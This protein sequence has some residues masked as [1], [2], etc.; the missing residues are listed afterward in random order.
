LHALQT[1]THPKKKIGVPSIAEMCDILANAI[2]IDI[3]VQAHNGSLPS[4]F[5]PKKFDYSDIDYTKYDT[6]TFIQSAIA[7][8]MDEAQEDF[9]ND[10]IAAYETFLVFLRTEE[11]TVDYTYLWDIVS[12]PNPR[13][14]HSGINLA[15]LEIPEND[16]TE[17]VEVV[18]PTAAYS[19]TIY[20]EKKDTLI[21]T[22]RT[23]ETNDEI[24]YFEPIYLYDKKQI[25]RK[26]SENTQIKPIQHILQIIRNF[27][28]KKCAPLKSIPKEYTFERNKSATQIREIC[29]KYNIDVLAQVLNFQGKI[30]AFL[31]KVPTG[32]YVYLPCAPSGMMSDI[33][34][35]IMIYDNDDDT[36]WQNYATTRD[37]LLQLSA[38]TRGELLCKP[39]VKIVEDELIVGI[40][41]ETNQFVMVNPPE[42]NYALDGLIELKDTNY[43]MADIDLANGR[44]MDNVRLRTVK[45]IRLEKYFYQVFRT[46][47][48]ILLNQSVNERTNI[49]K[50]IENL[51]YANY[52]EQLKSV[53][54]WLHKMMDSFVVFQTYDESVLMQLNEIGDCFSGEPVNCIFKSDARQLVIPERNSISGKMNSGVYFRRLADELLRY[55]RVRSMILDKHANIMQTDEYQLNTDE[56]ILLDYMLADYLNKDLVPVMKIKDARISYDFANPYKTT[57]YSNEVKLID[58]SKI[59]EEREP[60]QGVQGDQ[61]SDDKLKLECVKETKAVLGNTKN[62]WKQFFP[63]RSRELFLNSAVNC[64]YYPILII[65]KQVYDG[66]IITME[67][68]KKILARTYK[69]YAKFEPKILELLSLQGKRDMMEKVAK[70]QAT[71]EETIMSAM[72]PLSNLDYWVLCDVLKLPVILFTSMKNIKHLLNGESWIRLGESENYR[73]LDYYFIRAPTET[74]SKRGVNEI[75]AYSM[76]TPGISLEEMSDFQVIYSD[77]TIDESINLIDLKTYLAGDY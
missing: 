76:I 71:L 46:T 63:K 8:K 58:Q 6:S 28:Q 53:E 69:K 20:H 15:I 16:A 4:M 11:S 50:L 59:I 64:T 38:L 9:I 60:E 17:H 7:E 30:V 41:T 70:K 66:K 37:E 48:R 52:M 45:M 24:T 26:F 34:K 29:A 61:Q 74:D 56:M 72:Y 3:F 73:K 32:S 43:I 31:V 25:T 51:T 68:L 19:S 22:K 18:C 47:L 77:A 67:Q 57:K 75:H 49:M 62:M 35:T 65:Y 1:C 2:S 14:F 40:L 5:Q 44:K 54:L 13:L 21:L 23:S 33:E 39:V 10:T 12:L 27:S 42:E 55:K 36:L